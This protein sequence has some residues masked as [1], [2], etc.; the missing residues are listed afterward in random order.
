MPRGYIY[1]PPGGGPAEYPIVDIPDYIGHPVL[2]EDPAIVHDN[3]GAIEELHDMQF[4]QELMPR[5][6]LP[7]HHTHFLS[8]LEAWEVEEMSC[9]CS[10]LGDIAR[11]SFIKF[12]NQFV[13]AASSA[14]AAGSADGQDGDS[15]GFDKLDVT[16]LRNFTQRNSNA[17]IDSGLTELLFNGLPFMHQLALADNDQ[18]RDMLTRF[19]WARWEILRATA[20]SPL[21]FSRGVG[22]WLFDGPHDVQQRIEADFRAQAG[23]DD[24]LYPSAGYRRFR[25]AEQTQPYADTK[26]LQERAFVF[27]LDRRVQEIELSLQRRDE[28]SSIW[29]HLVFSHVFVEERL[30]GARVTRAQMERLEEDFGCA[31]ESE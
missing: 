14:S 29:S 6:R 5:P 8:R 22:G 19:D 3:D 23:Q 24:F 27:W 26:A 31:R 11:E 18:R 15:V 21:G 25:C 16:T 20:S 9:V 2:V 7:V 28:L 13:K 4:A 12:E 30:A 10:Y 1:I 17:I